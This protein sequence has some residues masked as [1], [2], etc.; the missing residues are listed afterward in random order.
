MPD[1][2]TI[3]LLQARILRYQRFAVATGQTRYLAGFY[4]NQADN[5]Y[6]VLWDL[7]AG[8]PVTVYRDPDGR[9]A[10]YRQAGP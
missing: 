4:Y 1:I 5:W 8:H 6:K 2:L 7:L 10:V 9:M 3:N